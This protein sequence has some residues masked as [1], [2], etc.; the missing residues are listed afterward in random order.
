MVLL[1]DDVHPDLAGQGVALRITKTVADPRLELRRGVLRIIQRVILIKFVE[2]LED[3]GRCGEPAET[4][5]RI[6]DLRFP[7]RIDVAQPDTAEAGVTRCLIARSS[8]HSQQGHIV[9]NRVLGE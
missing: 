2:R 7:I 5:C 1:S 8:A 3:T 6:R 4:R 9:E